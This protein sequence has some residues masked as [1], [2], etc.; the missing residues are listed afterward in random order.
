MVERDMR[1]NSSLFQGSR[2]GFSFE[3]H[4]PTSPLW[5][6]WVR[7]HTALMDSDLELCP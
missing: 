2:F 3:A 7:R 4:T 6:F 1:P 5:Q